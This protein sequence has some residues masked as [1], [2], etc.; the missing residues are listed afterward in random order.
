MN[1][2]KVLPDVSYCEW[3]G[4]FYVDWD[5]ET[6]NKVYPFQ[7]KKRKFNTIPEAERFLKSLQQKT[8]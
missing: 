6:G 8:S 1:I 2:T 4:M 7:A 5:I 3:D